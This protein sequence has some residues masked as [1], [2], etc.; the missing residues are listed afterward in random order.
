MQD[1][2]T[3]ELIFPAEELVS[4]ISGFCTLK[5]GDLIYTGTPGGVGM[6]GSRRFTSSRAT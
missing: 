6:D 1:S 5:P 2:N 3:V 4:Y